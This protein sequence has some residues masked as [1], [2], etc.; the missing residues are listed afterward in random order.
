MKRLINVSS[1]PK[2][3]FLVLLLFTLGSALGSCRQ[4]RN[5]SNPVI[6]VKLDEYGMDVEGA[7]DLKPGPAVIE[8][9]NNGKE[10][11]SFVFEGT[12]TV[13][14]L[15]ENIKPGETKTMNVNLEPASYN[16]YCP[17]DNHKNKGMAS[18]I[19][20]VKPEETGKPAGY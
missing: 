1:F 8:I 11:H 14:R 4:D 3:L 6:E 18:V 16:V 13:E 7:E 9:T 20:V 15:E 2:A 17:I 5:G 19:N 12:D 10:E